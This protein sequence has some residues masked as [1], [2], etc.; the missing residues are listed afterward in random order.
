MQDESQFKR[1]SDK[2]PVAS[3]R[4]EAPMTVRGFTAGGSGRASNEASIINAPRT[5]IVHDSD[6]IPVCASKVNNNGFPASQSCKAAKDGSPQRLSFPLARL[7]G[8][9]L[10]SE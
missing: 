5:Q 3:L 7:T 10:T 1:R 4:L 2:P 8:K 9:R 6:F